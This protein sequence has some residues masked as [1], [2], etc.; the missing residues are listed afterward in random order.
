MRVPHQH[1]L[2]KDHD[3]GPT[4]VDGEKLTMTWPY[5]ENYRQ[6]RLAESQRNRLPH[7]TAYKLLIK[8]LT[9]SSENIHTSITT[10]TEQGIFRNICYTHSHIDVRIDERK[11]YGL[12]ERGGVGVQLQEREGR[13]NYIF[14]SN[15]KKIIIWKEKQRHQKRK[16]KDTKAGRID[17]G[18]ALWCLLLL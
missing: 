17:S 13:C 10:Q 15:I 16:V 1:E 7:R 14:I 8:Y 2:I 11:G 18:K 3:S 12:K 6:L 4:K 9:V 5:P